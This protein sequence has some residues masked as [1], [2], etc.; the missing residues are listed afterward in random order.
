MSVNCESL[1]LS[2]KFATSATCVCLFQV[3][4]RCCVFHYQCIQIYQILSVDLLIDAGVRFEYANV[5][6]EFIA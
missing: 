6:T 2:A 3:G 1:C 5:P 4:P